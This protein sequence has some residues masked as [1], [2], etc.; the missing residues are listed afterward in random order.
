VSE[1]RNDPQQHRSRETYKRLIDAT[2]VVVARDG[3]QRA[4]TA[5]IAEESG[6]SIGTVYR[7]YPTIHEWRAAA[8][9]GVATHGIER[10]LEL[11]R[12]YRPDREVDPF[13]SIHFFDEDGEPE[14]ICAH[15]GQRWP[16]ATIRALQG[17]S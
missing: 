8:G 4:T 16:C 17:E 9:F 3:W 15:D 1:L 2:R 10:V 12:A 11:H 5:A 6:V 13:E 14:T 7:Y